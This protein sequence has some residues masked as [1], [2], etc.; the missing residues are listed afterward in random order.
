MGY[1]G[2]GCNE[3]KVEAVYRFVIDYKTAHGGDSPSTRQI[4]DGAGLSSSSV[5]MSY[6]R[7]LQEDGRI[8]LGHRPYS[9]MEIQVKGGVWVMAR[10]ESGARQEPTAEG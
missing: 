4:R 5:A 7:K 10:Q 2:R 9:G 1:N 8:T 3:E 6:L